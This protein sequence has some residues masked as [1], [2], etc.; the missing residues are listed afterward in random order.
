MF[1]IISKLA[2]ASS[3][4]FYRG[5]SALKKVPSLNGA[6]G[7]ELLITSA[8]L[9]ATEGVVPNREQAERVEAMLVALCLNAEGREALTLK[10]FHNL[11]TYLLNSL[12]KTLE[13]LQRKSLMRV[14]VQYREEET[15][16][17]QQIYVDNDENKSQLKAESEPTIDSHGKKAT[18]IML[19]I[20]PQDSNR[21]LLEKSGYTAIKYDT[22]DKLNDDFKSNIDVCACIVDE[23]F[24]TALDVSQQKDILSKLSSLSTLLWLRID[25]RGLKLDS[26][27]VRRILKGARCRST[28]NSEDLSIQPNGLL[29]EAELSEISRA[30]KILSIGDTVQLLPA[31]LTRQEL[32]LL[33]SAIKEHYQRY[34][35]ED[36]IA[37]KA[38]ETRF[39][40]GGLSGAKIILVNITGSNNFIIAKVGTKKNILDEMNRYN[41]FIKDWNDTL[42]PVASFHAASAVILFNFINDSADGANPAPVLEN[43]IEALWISELY[44]FNADEFSLKIRNLCTGFQRFAHSLSTLNKKCPRKAFPSHSNPDMKYLENVEARGINWGLGDSERRARIVA[45]QQFDKLAKSAIVHGDLHFKNILVRNELDFH[46]IDYAGSGPGHPAV[47]ICRIIIALFSVY[48]KQQ[49]DETQHDNIVDDILISNMSEVD[50]KA[51]YSPLYMPLSNEICIHGCIVSRD[52]AIETV[53][54]HQ[55]SFNDYIAALTLVAWQSLMISGKQTSL[56]RI[57]IRRLSVY[58]LKQ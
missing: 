12:A 18:V 45:Q 28:V 2:D 9:M 21:R 3:I 57:L 4:E 8:K 25:E 27:E 13:P 56:L 17:M 43:S 7:A 54:A 49:I 33:V 11:P 46:L 19:S 31:E 22:F 53:V 14:T 58:L 37:L 55:G 5:L 29:R 42:Q 24:L 1:E 30:Y 26:G 34:E 47:D 41:N 39:L 15:E 23:S 40:H 52:L 51:R 16:L 20:V 50:I 36:V 44:S 32:R 10:A 48:L 38:V 6:S 35:V